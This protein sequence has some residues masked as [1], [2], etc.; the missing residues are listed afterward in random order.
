M[1]SNVEGIKLGVTSSPVQVK[2]VD[3]FGKLT[4]PEN[5][6]AQNLSFEATSSLPY[7]DGDTRNR[8]VVNEKALNQTIMTLQSDV[9]NNVNI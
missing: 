7:F 5:T 2:F 3:S 1:T 8:R 9:L 6:R 4:N